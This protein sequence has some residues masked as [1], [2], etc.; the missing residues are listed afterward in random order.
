MIA[1]ILARYILS[2]S[3]NPAVTT[4]LSVVLS[5]LAL[6]LTILAIAGYWKIFEKAG[7][8][9]WFAVIPYLNEHERYNIAWPSQIWLFWV[10]LLLNVAEAVFSGGTFQANAIL[11]NILFCLWMIVRFPLC[12][13]LAKSFGKSNA[14]G[15]GLWL[16]DFVFA[17][18]LG[19]G[20]DAYKGPATGVARASFVPVATDLEGELEG[21]VANIV[22]PFPEAD[23]IV[24][25]GAQDGSFEASVEAAFEPAEPVVAEAAFE[26]VEPVVAEAPAEADIPASADAFEPLVIPDGAVISTDLRE[27]P[28]DYDAAAELVAEDADATIAAEPVDADATIIAEASIFQLDEERIDASTE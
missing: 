1:E 2:L 8:P 9:G 3:G 21:D 20:P 12:I 19:F 26:P 10:Y 27:A 28:A 24:V 18:M 15:I 7:R 25:E 4:S 23:A 22:T 16:A 13:A 11:T 6:V 14:F 17:P 5:L